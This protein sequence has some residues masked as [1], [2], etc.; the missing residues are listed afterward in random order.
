MVAIFVAEVSA[1]PIAL[2]QIQIVEQ[3]VVGEVDLRTMSRW[4]TVL[5]VLPGNA[6]IA[7]VAHLTF[8]AIGQALAGL[9]E[10]SRAKEFPAL[11]FPAV[12]K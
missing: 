11:L 7:A 5:I 3:P 10:A 6:T 1:L 2:S 4:K 8:F 9:R 12:Q